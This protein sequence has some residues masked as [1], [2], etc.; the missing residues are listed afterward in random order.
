[1]RNDKSGIGDLAG[2]GE[3]ANSKLANKL[4]DDAVKTTAQ[5]LGKSVAEVA[6][7]FEVFVAQPLALLNNRVERF[8][9]IFDKAASSVPVEQQ[10]QPNPKIIAS[11]MEAMTYETDEDHLIEAFQNLLKNSVM[12]NMT[13]SVHPSFVY[14][15][16]QLSP[17]DAALLSWIVALQQAEHTNLFFH[18]LDIRGIKNPDEHDPVD[19]CGWM[20]GIQEFNLNLGEL[21]VD[22]YKRSHTFIQRANAYRSISI[23]NLLRLGIIEEIEVVN[24]LEFKALASRF[25]IPLLNFDHPVYPVENLYKFGVYALTHYGHL[26]SKCVTTKVLSDYAEDNILIGENQEGELYSVLTVEGYLGL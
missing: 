6:R 1:M 2:I 14:V 20:T 9:S 7:T 11:I 10:V 8:W 23:T 5:R 22:R 24:P 26:F 4:Y 3:V 12:R 25:V 16:K 18:A 13:S 21:V 15:L 17:E 19:V